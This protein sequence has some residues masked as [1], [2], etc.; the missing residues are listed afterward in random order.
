M[1][2]ICLPDGAVWNRVACR[3]EPDG[4]DL[5]AGWSRMES[6][7]LPDGA[8]WNRFACLVES[9]AWPLKIKFHFIPAPTRYNIIYG[10]RLVTSLL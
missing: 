7:C 6:S 1:E 8:G 4:I 3:M 2:S 5:L 9:I 10:Y